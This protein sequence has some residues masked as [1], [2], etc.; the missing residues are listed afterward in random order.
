VQHAILAKN[1]AA[2]LRVYAIWFN[3]LPGD[4]RQRW[5]DAGLRDPRALHY[6]DEQQA[7]GNW[8]T[9]NVSKAR[10][11]TWD[12]Y[13]LYGP[14]AHDLKTPSSHGRTIIGQRSQLETSIAP[15]LRPRS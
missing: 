14:E 2:D 12:Y 15:L 9:A 1:P 5:D 4:S 3:V 6:W 11:I 10:G 13:A 8:F 7:V